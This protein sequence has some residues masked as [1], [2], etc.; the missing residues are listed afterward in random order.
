MSKK[1]LPDIGD[2]E[3]RMHKAYE[4]VGTR[5]PRCIICGEAN[6]LRLRLHHPAQHDFDA[7]KTVII[8]SSHHDDASD[9]QKEHPEKIQ[10]CTSVLEPVGHLVLGLGDLA[11]IAAH[12]HDIGPLKEFLLYVAEELRALGRELIELA[13]STTTAADGVP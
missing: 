12:E 11:H 9:W 10:W 2:R 3:E 5:S 1:R 8:C 4:R 7:D 13:R 6:P